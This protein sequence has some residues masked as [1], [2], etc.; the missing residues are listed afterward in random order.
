MKYFL[1]SLILLLQACQTTAPLKQDF[2]EAPSSLMT[3]CPSLKT[4]GETEVQMS[5]LMQ[6]VVANYKEYHKCAAKVEGWIEWHRANEQINKN[7]GI[8]NQ[9]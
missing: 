4:L 2:P 3:Q 9:N 7:I 5:E 1:L 6:V 8:N